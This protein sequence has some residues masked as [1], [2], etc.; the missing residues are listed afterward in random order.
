MGDDYEIE[1]DGPIAVATKWRRP[2]MEE[3]KI[4]V[5]Q[6]KEKKIRT[7]HHVENGE[8]LVALVDLCDSIG[9]RRDHALQTLR[10]NDEVP[11]SV[12]IADAL[13][14]IQ[15]T[16]FVNEPQVNLIVMSC[17]SDE[18]KPVRKWLAYEVIPAIRKTGQYVAKPRNSK[19]MALAAIEMLQEELAAEKAANE[20][21]RAKIIELAPKAAFTD[22]LATME[23][24]MEIAEAAKRYGYGPMKLREVM[25]NIKWLR[26]D[27]LPYET[28]V[29]NGNMET[30]VG[31]GT[32]HWHKGD[33][34]TR[35]PYSKPLITSKGFV[36][37]G[38]ILRDMGII[39]KVVRVEAAKKEAVAEL[40]AEN[41]SE[42]TSS[43]IVLEKK[44]A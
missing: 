5:Y 22:Q 18:C 40:N 9:S 10:D 25:R 7:A 35:N 43:Q 2:S 11:I 27:N 39:P 17:R 23:S 42:Q 12:P 26:H 44:K 13:G 6:F 4:T 41:G 37:L 14:R 15:Q 32:W 19:E 21:A 20:N 28:Q 3:C 33:D 38:R 34:N 8:P 30:Y 31:S 36:A 1:I 29:L 16:A 24:S